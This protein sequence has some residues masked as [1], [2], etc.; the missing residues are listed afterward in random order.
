M[1]TIAQVLA[2][3]RDMVS[4]ISGRPAEVTFDVYPDMTPPQKPKRKGWVNAWR[5]DDY[6]PGEGAGA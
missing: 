1:K 6:R 3:F 5:D 2:T 4:P